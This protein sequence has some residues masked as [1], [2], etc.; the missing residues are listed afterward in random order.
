[1]LRL[2]HSFSKCGLNAFDKPSI[3]AM[4]ECCRS[5]FRDHERCEII[6]F[7]MGRL[8]M[9]QKCLPKRH[10][11]PLTRNAEENHLWGIECG[12]TCL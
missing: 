5:V 10:C 2:I 4:P 8:M 7:Q 1:M 6:S 12:P 9:S 3:F 11:I